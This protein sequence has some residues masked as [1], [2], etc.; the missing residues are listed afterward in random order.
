MVNMV[1]P[2]E[3]KYN[4][5]YFSQSKVVSVDAKDVKELISVGGKV[6]EESDVS[7][8]SPPVRTR[9]VSKK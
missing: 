1:F 3:I 2:F 7:P 6:L 9:R 4:G 5:E 8:P